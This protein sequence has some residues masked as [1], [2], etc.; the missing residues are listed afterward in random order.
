MSNLPRDRPVTDGREE[1][2]K[3]QEY[4]DEAKSKRRLRTRKQSAKKAGDYSTSTTT[5]VGVSSTAKNADSLVALAP[6]SKRS[7]SDTHRE[8]RAAT[9]RS[10]LGESTLAPPEQAVPVPR[11]GESPK[12]QQETLAT[13]TAPSGALPAETK[14]SRSERRQKAKRDK[15]KAAPKAH[16][17][18]GAQKPARDGHRASS[19]KTLKSKS[20]KAPLSSELEPD[21]P[22]TILDTNLY[23]DGL[24]VWINHQTLGLPNPFEICD[25]V[26]A[27]NSLGVLILVPARTRTRTVQNRPFVKLFSSIP[28]L[29]LNYKTHDKSR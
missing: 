16:P 23:M 28:M 5:D 22:R 13:T 8:K 6:P 12:P 2:L 11:R 9:K 3:D 17:V 26:R 24:T 29:V 21:A 7:G 14:A 1:V 4:G 18:P 25:A 15:E 10:S 20:R 27:L 19:H